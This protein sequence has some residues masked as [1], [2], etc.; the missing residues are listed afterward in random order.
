MLQGCLKEQGLSMAMAEGTMLEK[1]LA[2]VCAHV[3]L[4]EACYNLVIDAQ[5]ACSFMSSCLT[6]AWWVPTVV[7]TIQLC[8]T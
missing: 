2:S 5:S 4:K 1:P 3:T 8:K 6:A 7:D